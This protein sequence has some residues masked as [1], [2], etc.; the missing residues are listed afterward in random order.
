MLYS[1]YVLA[2]GCLFTFYFLFELA[3]LGNK[4]AEV[5][6]CYTAVVVKITCTAYKQDI[7]LNAVAVD[8]CAIKPA[9]NRVVRKPFC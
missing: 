9:C 4:A 8:I 7:A 1:A 5:S 3:K 2:D 6:A